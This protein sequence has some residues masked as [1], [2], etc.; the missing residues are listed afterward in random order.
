MLAVWRFYLEHEKPKFANPQ[1]FASKFAVWQRQVGTNGTAGPPDMRGQLER[2]LAMVRRQDPEFQGGVP[3]PHA[4]GFAVPTGYGGL[5]DEVLKEAG[6]KTTAEMQE[7][8]A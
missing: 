6:L 1:D 4:T 3:D 8:S 5:W 2:G 7:S